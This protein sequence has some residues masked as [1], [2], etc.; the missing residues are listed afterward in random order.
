MSR[1]ELA[2]AVNAYLWNKYKAR[3]RLD[4]K[5]VGKLERGENRW[6]RERRREAFRAVLRADEDRQLGFYVVRGTSG[7]RS[8]RSEARPNPA[9]ASG[10]D[11]ST[12][13]PNRVFD[14]GLVRLTGAAWFGMLPEDLV[15]LPGP[16]TTDMDTPAKIEV[17]HVEALRRSIALFEHWD[18]QYGGGLARA[19]MSGQLQWACR[20]ARTSVMTETTRQAWQSVAARLG[21][22]AGWACFDAGERPELVQH[23]FLTAIQLAGE[24]NDVQQRTHTATSMSRHLTYLGRTSEALDIV[25]LA[26]LGWR[27]LP[28]LGRAVIGIAE[29]RTHGKIGD[30]QACEQAVQLCDHH[31][32]NRSPDGAVDPTW[33][34]YADAAQILGDAG[35]A[36]FDLAMASG[37]E[38][39]AD[40]T[41]NRLEA[42]Y[43]RHPPETVR[44]KA[45]TMIRIACLKARH[46]DLGEALDAA[47]LGIADAR[48]VQSGRVAD[49]L[50]LLDTVLASVPTTRDNRDRLAKVRASIVTPVR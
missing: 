10:G 6:P 23:Y 37:D 18:H 3:E 33:G 25:G 41:I 4:E 2:E 28:H 32:A 49:D 31:F 11:Y 14:V 34:Y 9:V 13:S 15:E 38:D 48:E 45:L 43:A 7:A 1:Q 29:A 8:A 46:R 44:S 27:E 20:A 21:D 12:R 26:R 16:W 24:A 42:A 22:L 47:D 5:D 30:R 50:R 36:L 35:H 17:A 19:A 39:Q 40:A